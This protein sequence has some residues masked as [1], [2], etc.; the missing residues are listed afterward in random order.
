MPFSMMK[1]RDAARARVRVGLGVDD[2]R[3]GDRAVGDPHLGAVQH[4]AVALLLG[5][6]AHGDDVGAGARLGHG[7]RADMLAGDQLRQVA[8]LLLLAAV[9]ADLVHAEVGMRAVAEPDGG[10]G[11]GHLLH[12]DAMLEIAEAGAAD[13]PPPP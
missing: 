10:R 3:L 4:V 8:P 11:A 6:R 1:A 7:E 2:E 5:P 12:R 13:T 9:A